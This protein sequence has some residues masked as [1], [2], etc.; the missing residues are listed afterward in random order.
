MSVRFANQESH[1]AGFL[2]S[3]IYLFI[4]YVFF[5]FVFAVGMQGRDEGTG[6]VTRPKLERPACLP[7][8]SIHPS[9]AMVLLVLHLSVSISSVFC[10]RFFNIFLDASAR[11]RLSDSQATYIYIYI[12]LSNLHLVSL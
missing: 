9:P 4:Y 3:F 7:L 11:A 8:S 6:A 12:S 5:C 1:S 2:L 10:A